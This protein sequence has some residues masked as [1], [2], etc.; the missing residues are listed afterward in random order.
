MYYKGENKLKTFSIGLPD[1]EDLKYAK[2]V[3]DYLDTDHHEIIVTEDDFFNAIEDVIKTI[4]SYDTTTVRA[5][6]G[7]Y[8]IGKYIREYTE[9]KV[10]FNG[11]G[12][13]EL[14]GGYLYFNNVPNE[15]EFDKECTH[16]LDNIC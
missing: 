6:V 3:A 1:S 4:E 10:I 12:S 15:Y 11:D 14:T 9:C 13:D 7:N 5:S 16:L 2:I 8:L